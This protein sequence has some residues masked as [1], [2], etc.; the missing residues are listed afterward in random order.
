[1]TAHVKIDGDCAQ[2]ELDGEVVEFSLLDIETASKPVRQ[3]WRNVRSNVEYFVMLG[4]GR[5]R[6]EFGLKKTEGILT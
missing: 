4:F 2:V 1:M 5:L 6:K 3:A